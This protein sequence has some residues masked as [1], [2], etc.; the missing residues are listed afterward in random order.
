M[1]K[2]FII[3]FI[4]ILNI[5]RYIIHLKYVKQDIY[6]NHFDLAQDNHI[7][8]PIHIPD[9]YFYEFNDGYDYINYEFQS[10]LITNGLI[11]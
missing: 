2:V 7:C 9:R 4:S 6:L 8:T 1:S 11:S 5:I 10:H 3:I